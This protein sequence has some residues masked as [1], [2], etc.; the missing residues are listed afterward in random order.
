MDPNQQPLIKQNPI[1]QQPI[2]QIPS[3]GSKLKWVLLII[4]LLLIVGGGAYYLGKKQNT[5]LSKN[6]QKEANPT[7]IQLTPTSTS[8][9]IANWQTYVSSQSI[10]GISITYPTGWKVNYK[11][12]F[13]LSSDYTANY[14]ATF[15]FAPPGWSNPNAVGYMGWVAVF[16]DVYDSQSDINHF[17]NKYYLDYKD[18][19]KAT[20]I[21]DIDNKQT[22]LLDSNGEGVFT[23]R[24]VILGTNYSYEM[25]FGNG[26]DGNY[27][28]EFE[29]EFDPKI[30][31]D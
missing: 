17:I 15:D 6:Q 18:K 27:V 8:S 4:A 1:P 3:S 22:F 14:R 20:K 23:P 5:A 16:F 25:S 7:A 29:K 10:G 26:E 13:N 28:K 31:I 9:P 11:K 30:H 21:A 2:N 19:I 24:T 12:E